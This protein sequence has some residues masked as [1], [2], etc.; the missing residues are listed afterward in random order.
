M[1]VFLIFVSDITAWIQLLIGNEAVYDNI[2]ITDFYLS[3]ISF[4]VYVSAVH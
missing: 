4:A 2:L 1:W 3:E